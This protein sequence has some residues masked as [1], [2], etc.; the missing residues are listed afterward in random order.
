MCVGV[1]GCA[2]VD[3]C[4][5]VCVSVCIMCI[6]VHTREREGEGGR[7]RERGRC[8]G[9]GGIERRIR[10]LFAVFL[11]TPAGH[12]CMCAWGVAMLCAC[13]CMPLSLYHTE[14]TSC[15]KHGDGDP[16]ISRHAPHLSRY[17]ICKLPTSVLA[18]ERGTYE[19]DKLGV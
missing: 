15:K 3:L 13:A 18:V 19:R 11:S 10:K 5:T 17:R 1:G 14:L 8:G 12:L 7:E 2:F 6:C 4:T 16:K 9:E